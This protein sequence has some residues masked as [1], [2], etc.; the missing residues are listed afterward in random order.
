MSFGDLL[1]DL[2]NPHGAGFEEFITWNVGKKKLCTCRRRLEWLGL[3]AFSPTQETR[4]KC[5]GPGNKRRCPFGH[6]QHASHLGVCRYRCPDPDCHL[7]FCSQCVGGGRSQ[8]ALAKLPLQALGSVK[9]Q[10]LMTFVNKYDD[11]VEDAIELAQQFLALGAKFTEP[12]EGDWSGHLY[13]GLFSASA[14]L[15]LVVFLE[16]ELPHFGTLVSWLKTCFWLLA[17]C[18]LMLQQAAGLR[19]ARTVLRA[20]KDYDTIQL[21]QFLHAPQSRLKRRG[22]SVGESRRGLAR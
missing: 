22:R 9:F 17:G 21:S 13:A 10:Q 1:T 12:L 15:L 11:A 20:M 2:K 16:F 18:G 7:N 8:S 3:G 14:G 19:R 5:S 6:N 4:W